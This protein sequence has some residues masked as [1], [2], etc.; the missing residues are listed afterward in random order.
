MRR[1]AGAK[2]LSRL[3]I[4]RT[5]TNRGI[6]LPLFKKKRTPCP[7][8]TH[9]SCVC[10]SKL[11]HL[12]CNFFFLSRVPETKVTI[13]IFSNRT[14]TRDVPSESSE[15]QILFR[16]SG[17]LPPQ[18]CPL[19]NSYFFLPGINVQ[20]KHQT[21]GLVAIPLGCALSTRF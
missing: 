7:C 10:I 2:Q 8:L 9:N 1:C 20:S 6:I 18:T 17:V 21:S 3:N 5:K 11:N 4:K 13:I 14:R 15:N 19:S 16:I 12:G